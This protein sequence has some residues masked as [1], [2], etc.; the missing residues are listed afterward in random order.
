MSNPNPLLITEGLPSFESIEPG[1]VEEA[2]NSVLKA[3]RADL[4][5][6]LD[7]ESAP[8]WDRIVVPLEEMEDRLNR[9]WSP[10]RHLNAVANNKA[11]R[12]AHNACLPHITAYAT[13]L[14]Q[15]ENLYKAYKYIATHEYDELDATQQKV[16]DDALRDFHLAG[17]DLAANDKSRFK[18]IMQELAQLGSRFEEN[19]LDSMNAFQR[20]V[21]KES[22]LDGLPDNDRQRASDNA[23]RENRSGFLLSLDYPT[24][25]AILTYA[26][27]REL[28]REFHEAWSTRA[29]DM[30]PHA[31][32]WDNS[33]VIDEIL[34]LRHEAAEILGFDNYCELSLATKMAGT[35]PEV[36]SFLEDLADRS[37]ELARRDITQLQELAGHELEAWD[38]SFYGEKLKRKRFEISDEALRPYFP[39]ER[40]LDGL[41]RV[42]QTLFG[43]KIARRDGVEVWHPDVAFYE[44]SNAAGDQIGGFFVDLY[45][46][47]HKRGGAWMDECAVRKKL[48]ARLQLPV[49]YLVCNFP[50]PVRNSASLLNHDDVVTLF[51]EFGHT[52]HHLLTRVDIPS[53]AGINGVPW[54]AVELPSQFMENFAWRREVLPWISGHYLTGEPMPDELF[55]RLLSTRSFLGGM[56][57]VRQLEFALFDF[58]LHAEYDPHNKPRVLEILQQ[59]RDRV[60]VVP[61]TS[62]NRFPNSFSHIFAGGYAAGYYS[63]KWA[64]VLAAD[65]FAAFAENGVF[66][67]DTAARF[68]AEILEVGGTRDAMAAYVAFRGREPRLEPLLE[69]CGINKAA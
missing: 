8:S 5:R 61:D 29:S 43:L 54:D 7:S 41:F 64:E 26:K 51:H 25:H 35:V 19:V 37:V 1:H 24:Y 12:D 56:Q 62:F 2:I 60:A 16:I 44:I 31:G 40:V 59:I 30:G 50:P 34:R 27:N 23:R 69:Q 11:L 38:I 49:A 39:S 21:E 58:R 52:L 55:D 46:R 4:Q 14:G 67:E 28:R 57:M 22:D 42:A 13:E 15:N 17:V 45:A 10:V 47:K 9:V 33:A 68:R 6:L 20:H 65:A 63:Y 32:R 36:L 66:D 53:V 18:A 48:G 3:N